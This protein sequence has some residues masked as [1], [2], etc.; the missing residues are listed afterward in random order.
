[1]L[2]GLIAF[3]LRNRLFVVAAAAMLM[4]YGGYL[5][6]QLPVD[7]LPDLNRPTV[8]IFLE[9]EGLA[10]EEV[11]TLVALPVEAAMNG[12][13]GVERVRSVSS[14]GLALVFVEF[15]WNTDLYID[16]QIV[17]EK[18]ASVR[19]SIPEDVNPVL[20]P[21]TS[22]MG[23]IM[24]MAVTSDTLGPMAIRD[25]ADWRIRPRLLAVPGVSQVTVIG[26]DVPQYQVLAQ[27][28]RL[29]SQGVTLH[30]LESA[31][32]ESNMN[33]TG[34]F[35]ID[36]A[37]ESVVRNLARF[38]TIDDIRN[39]VVTMRGGVPVLIGAVAD[40]RIGTGVKRGDAGFNAGPAVILSI[41]KQPGASTTDLTEAILLELDD[42]ETSLPPGV[43]IHRGVFQQARFI[44]AAIGNVV[45]ALRDGSIFVA[46]ILFLFLMNLRTTFI[47]LT[48]IPLSLVITAIVFKFFG[49]SINT[50]TLGGL[51]VA[52]G[53]VVDDAI[54]D[55]E[56]IHRRLR[57]NALLPDP[58]PALRVV[59]EASSEV[60]SSIVYATILVILV[61]IPLFAMG[62]IE[63]KIFAPLG[64]AY[65]ISIA[66]SLLVSLTVT[67]ALSSYLLQGRGTG[68]DK[69]DTR[70][71]RWLKRADESIVLR[72][73]LRRPGLYMLAALGVLV[74]AI[75]AATRFG[76]EFLPPFNEG[77]V[78][79]NLLLPPGTSLEESNRIG[80]QAERLLLGIPG[81]HETGRRTGRAEQDEHAES[82]SSTE[83]EVEI[84]ET[85][86][87]RE[88]VLNEMRR[89]LAGLPGVSVNIGQPISHRIDH[90]LSGTRAQVAVKLFGPDLETLREKGEEIRRVVSE[91]P[92]VVDLFVEQQTLIPQTRVE[93][94]RK[95]LVPYGL[96]A[97]E[98]AEVLETALSGLTAGQVV[99]G[100]RRYDLVLRL[101]EEARGSSRTLD[102]VL[103]DTE[104]GSLI[105]LKALAV[106]RDAQGPNQILR[107][108][109]SR[110]IVVQCNVSG[111]SLGS[112]IG[113]IRTAV[114]EH[115]PLPAGYH[116]VYGGQ[117]ESQER[118][119]RLIALLSLVSLAGMCIVLYVHFRS[120][121]LVAQVLL[122]IPFALV[123]AIA[124]I[125]LTGGVISI[126]SLVAFITLCGIASRNGIMMLS[127]YLH[128][129]RH[130]GEKFDTSMI[131][132]GSLERLVPVLM[133][134]GA[135]ILGLIPL[136][137][138]RGEAGKEILYPVAAVVFGGLISSTL[139]DIVLT[140]AV[141]WKFGRKATE[142]V[143]LRESPEI[144]PRVFPETW[145]R[146]RI[147]AGESD[148]PERNR[149]E[150]TL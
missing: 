38:E 2:N 141:F 33:T 139:L 31:L 112:V 55:V 110:R 118:A 114:S 70:F 29:Q 54:V 129:M 97:G 19:G 78:T 57:E 82:V 61:F 146:G 89:L 69:G 85:T 1:M 113:E 56:N 109:G 90:L 67:P 18:L 133:T 52:L 93:I 116:I 37:R 46:L 53:E 3:S 8:T 40:V 117:F 43:K 102:E 138:A 41:Q 100:Q 128:L 15:G 80:R 104:D 136:L 22:I 74:V 140:P 115:V 45:E 149:P 24:L 71:V 130:E 21:V 59:F 64:L 132:R 150:P 30:D 119:T 72:H 25:L 125:A 23:E 84:D 147:P 13:T 48:A 49:I 124:A 111:R 7:V 143:F 108:N 99:E 73:T 77:S 103:I 9:A 39:T 75:L 127:H 121:R 95:K 50:M 137:L 106:V 32:R 94:D 12:A 20:G 123:G 122:N 27:P 42:V 88:E 62:G 36:G 79:I 11:E 66:A 81:V 134:A 6:T 92:G 4:A 68:R 14:L 60:R 34:G 96:H 47:T 91:V 35:L 120:W 10:P 145:G 144:L 44:E 58:R 135:A 5:L 105:P 76:T 83:I 17:A 101:P 26:G 16:R 28:G 63:G 87:S 107:E 148:N 98:V 51:A 131:V 65:I 86:G 126:A 142:Q